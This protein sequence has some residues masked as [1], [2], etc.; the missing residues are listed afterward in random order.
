M[1][2]VFVLFLMPF[3]LMA[4]KKDIV[5]KKLANLTCECAATKE[6]TDVN[7]GLCI[8][9]SINKLSDKEQKTVNVDSNDRMA[10][11]EK[12]AEKVGVEMAI[13]CPDIFIKMANGENAETASLADDAELD[14]FYTGTF[15]GMTNAEFSTIALIDGKKE[16]HEFI[17]LFSFEGDNLFLKNKIVKGDSLEIHYRQQEFYDPKQKTYRIYNE[18]TSVKLL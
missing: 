2:S 3:F 17:W 7:L 4:Q 6:A 8:F 10:S 1:K 18:I 12:I 15:E 16:R 14:L 13:I 9:A 5:Y 11:I